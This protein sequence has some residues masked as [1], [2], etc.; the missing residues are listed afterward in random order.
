MPEIRVPAASLL[1]GDI[2]ITGIRGA[3]SRTVTSVSP[4]TGR[5]GLI[6]VSTVAS[7]DPDWRSRYF[8]ARRTIVTV[9]RPGARPKPKPHKTSIRGQYIYRG[10]KITRHRRGRY[11]D[12]TPGRDHL[13]QVPSGWYIDILSSPRFR[14]LADACLFLDDLPD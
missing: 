11:D 14:T 3:T 8:T 13:D 12:G 10:H 6:S 9:D 2:I 5:S 1:P 4:A 7:D